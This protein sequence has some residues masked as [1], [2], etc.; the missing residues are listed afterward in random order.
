MVELVVMCA[1]VCL[2]AFEVAATV[3]IAVAGPRCRGLDVVRVH[4]GKSG[5]ARRADR[6]R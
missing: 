4:H 2:Q 1:R 5:C 6:G 3:D